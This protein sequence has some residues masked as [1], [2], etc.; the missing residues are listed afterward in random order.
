MFGGEGIGVEPVVFKES[1]TSIEGIR[2][3]Y[4]IDENRV[5][6]HLWADPEFP[7]ETGAKLSKG[8]KQFP[9]ENV[10]VDFVPEVDSWYV[11]VNSLAVSPTD[12]LVESI[13]K[14][15]AKA[16]NGNG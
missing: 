15:M 10:I 6:F 1:S 4:H 13:V 2:V 16:V 5:Q 9:N 8:L 7:N 14:K 12:M 3:E 11:E